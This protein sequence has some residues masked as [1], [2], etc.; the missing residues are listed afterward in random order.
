M[1]AITI[2]LFNREI[3]EFYLWNQ[4]DMQA[5]PF[6]G[7]KLSLTTG[8]DEKP[9]LHQVHDVHFAPKGIYVYAYYIGSVFSHAN[10]G[11][12]QLPF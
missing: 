6:I 2:F 9:E 1:I 11:Y 3:R 10:S 4:V 7:S 8:L 5:V 12:P